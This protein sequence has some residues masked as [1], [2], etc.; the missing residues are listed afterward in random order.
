MKSDSCSYAYIV[1]IDSSHCSVRHCSV[2]KTNQTNKREKI[3]TNKNTEYDQEIPQSQ[4][5]DKPVAS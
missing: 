4:S 5:A 3:S 1:K 2:R